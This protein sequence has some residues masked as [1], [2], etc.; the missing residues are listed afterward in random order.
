MLAAVHLLA[1]ML[2]AAPRS[3]AATREAAQQSWAA[4][5]AAAPQPGAAGRAA[6]LASRDW[7]QMGRSPS[8][9]STSNAS[10]S[11]APHAEWTFKGA[12]SRLISSPA[13][14]DGIAYVGCDDGH[15]YAL[16]ANTGIHSP[17][18]VSRR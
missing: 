9:A 18:D 14:Y 10:I 13:I 11:G 12:T 6:P 5:A 3:A 7:P 1:L 16:D 2:H 15:L 17:R 4:A 8:F